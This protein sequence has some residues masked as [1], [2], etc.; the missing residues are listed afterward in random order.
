MALILNNRYIVT[1]TTTIHYVDDKIEIRVPRVDIVPRHC[2][3]RNDEII[4]KTHPATDRM[5]SSWEEWSSSISYHEMADY[6][7]QGR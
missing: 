1:L 2:F 7:R 4:D 6:H 3:A 5:R